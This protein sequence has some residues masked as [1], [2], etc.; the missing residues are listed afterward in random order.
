MYRGPFP[1]GSPASARRGHDPAIS[2]VS[3][4]ALMDLGYRVDLEAADPFV[5]GAG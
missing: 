5:L 4:G 1:L 3:L 2:R